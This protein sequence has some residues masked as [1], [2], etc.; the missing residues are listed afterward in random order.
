MIPLDYSKAK[1]KNLLSIID[2]PTHE[3]LLFEIIDFLENE[4]RHD[5]KFTTHETYLKTRTRILS[6]VTKDLNK[7]VEL[8]YLEKHKQSTYE[9]IK[10][11]WE[12]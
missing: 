10:H 7:L 9:V 6:S 1:I 5:G 2:E 12:K 4:N 11:C 8:G 3:D